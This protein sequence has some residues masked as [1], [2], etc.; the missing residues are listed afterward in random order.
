MR[1]IHPGSFLWKTLFEKW[2]GEVDGASLRDVQGE[3]LEVLAAAIEDMDLV[4][5]QSPE[6]TGNGKNPILPLDFSRTSPLS[7]QEADVLE[8]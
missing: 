7:A 1:I 6:L 4:V 8:I 3:T 2:A 5:I